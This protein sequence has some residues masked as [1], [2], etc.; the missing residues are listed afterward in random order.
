MTT[1]LGSRKRPKTR[2]KRK[3]PAANRPAKKEWLPEDGIT[4]G[5]AIELVVNGLRPNAP[6]ELTEYEAAT[7]VELMARAGVTHTVIAERLGISLQQA[8]RWANLAR[9]GELFDMLR[10]VRT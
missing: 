8:G 2:G 10:K 7:C 3:K 5:I 6:P 4:D 1:A 9:K